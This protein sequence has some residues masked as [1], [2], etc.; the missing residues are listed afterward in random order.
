MEPVTGRSAKEA[1]SR[2][3]PRCGERPQG[4]ISPPGRVLGLVTCLR[5]RWERR[6]PISRTPKPHGEELAGPCC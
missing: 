2:R 5:D 6:E 4:W 1:P 3:A